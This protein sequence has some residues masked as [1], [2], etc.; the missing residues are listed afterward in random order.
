M[1]VCGAVLLACA[2]VHNQ[3]RDGLPPQSLNH[4]HA[5]RRRV[6]HKLPQEAAY[7]ARGGAEPVRGKEDV[8]TQGG[9]EIRLRTLLS[10]PLRPHTP[11]PLRRPL[12]YASVLLHQAVGQHGGPAHAHS[13]AH[14]LRQTRREGVRVICPRKYAQICV[15]HSLHRAESRQ[16]WL[17]AQQGGVVVEAQQGAKLCANAGARGEGAVEEGAEQRPMLGTSHLCD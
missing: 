6:C 8:H 4:R 5:L 7:T 13:V 12:R 11:L 9:L 10:L 1:R 14:L 17:C 3:L 2:F 15:T 16:R